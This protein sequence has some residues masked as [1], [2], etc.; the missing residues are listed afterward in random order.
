LHILAC[1][2]QFRRTEVRK[3]A[4][5]VGEEGLFSYICNVCAIIELFSV[6]G[7]IDLN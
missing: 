5:V 7:G 3:V 2:P 6:P 1:I 4:A